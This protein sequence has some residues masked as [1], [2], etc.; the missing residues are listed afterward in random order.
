[1][2]EGLGIPVAFYTLCAAI[3]SKVY[4][5]QSGLRGPRYIHKVEEPTWFCTVVVI[6]GGPGIALM[7]VF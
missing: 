5:K 1:M 6:Y 2:F 4:A 3:D 7:T